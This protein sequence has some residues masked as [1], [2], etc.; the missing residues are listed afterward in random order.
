M[1]LFLLQKVTKASPDNRH[2]FY[3]HFTCAVD[4]ENIR[5]VFND[6]RDIIQ[7]IHL[8]QYE[9]L[10]KGASFNEENYDVIFLWAKKYFNLLNI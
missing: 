7:R 3:T 8:R 10:W 5:K 6:C 2:S 9:L 1:S 4:T